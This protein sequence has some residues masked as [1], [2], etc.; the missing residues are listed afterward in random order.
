MDILELSQF[1]PDDFLA[2]Y[3]QQKPVVIRQ[4]FVHFQDLISP[5]ELAGLAC[6]PD[7]ESRLVYQTEGLWQA[8]SGPFESYEHLG[9]QG[10]C[11]IVQAVDHWSP[12]VAELVK[13]FSFIPKWRFDD[14][15]ISY[16]TP[17]GGVGP[18]IDL[19]DVFICQGSG[20]RRWRVGAPGNHR[21]FAAH[22]ALLHTDPFE[23]IIDVE[24]QSGDILYIPPGFPHDGVSLEH[25][26]SFSVG[27]RSKSASHML[28]GLADY[29]LDKELGGALI[30]DPQRPPHMQQGRIDAADFARIKAQMQALLDDD[31]LIAD[32]AGSFLSKNK[33]VLDLQS[34]EE[35]FNQQELLA[36]L[37]RQPLVRIGGLRCFYVDAT[38]RAG[39]CYI[40]G[41]RHE[42]GAACHD[43]V[44]KLC[45]HEILS[46]A[47]LQPYLK[48]TLLL[49]ALTEWVNDGYWYFED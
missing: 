47:M 3:W 26:M 15:M 12:Q 29:L 24:L 37:Q 20:R 28:S 33:S 25:S 1:S 43:A 41:E 48:Q 2:N 9:E 5:D 14:V 13:P 38:V 31:T 21:Q 34:L 19:Y 45:D 49:A 22:A 10:W 16:S 46:H 40:D 8:E 7:V 39:V 30:S 23:A 35:P 17:G 11:L 32:F 44:L 36:E 6:E 27:F 4:G 18:H 42:F